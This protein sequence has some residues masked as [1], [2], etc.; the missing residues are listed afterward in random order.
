MPVNCCGRA[1]NVREAKHA[2]SRADFIH[3]MSIALKESG[4]TS[5]WLELLF[6]RELLKINEYQ[7]IKKDADELIKILHSIVKS[8]KRKKSET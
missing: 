4:E 8:S 6:A 2:E 5:Y 1:L 7:S 3:K